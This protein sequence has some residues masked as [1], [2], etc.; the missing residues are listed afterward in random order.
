MSTLS[1]IKCAKSSSS[2]QRLHY[3][4]DRSSRP[5]S[6]SIL[7]VLDRRKEK[8]R[9]CKISASHASC[10]MNTADYFQRYYWQSKISSD[11]Y[12][13][14]NSF[15]VRAFATSPS[16]ENKS[17]GTKVIK[18]QKVSTEKSYADKALDLTKA[19]VKLLIN[20]I[21]KTP[22]VLWY[23][24]SRPKELRMKL[25]EFRDL[26]KKEANHYYMG[27]KLLIA[28]IRTARTI[29][30]RTLNG[31]H[32]TRRERKQLVRTVSDVFRL[33]PMSVFV[34]VPFMEFLLPIALKVRCLICVW[35]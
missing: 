27:S 8:K 32:L 5:F 28:D 14:G 13:P 23:F 24:L 12:L 19:G 20:F 1:L 17:A 16:E 4:F 15:G 22:G 30:L 26:V 35:L 2:L 10:H 25:I 21:I 34:L 9:L 29:L 7:D 3:G 31:S 18:I 6:C 11:R 33:V